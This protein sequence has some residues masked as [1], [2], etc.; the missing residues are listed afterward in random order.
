MIQ[1]ESSGASLVA[2]AAIKYFSW[3]VI[4][5]AILYFIARYILPML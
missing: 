5:V 2:Y 3:I 1:Q 4:V